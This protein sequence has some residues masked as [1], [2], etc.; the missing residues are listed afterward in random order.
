MQT[1]IRLI[2]YTKIQQSYKTS[3]DYTYTGDHGIAAANLCVS[4]KV[5]DRTKDFTLLE[6]C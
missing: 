3:E 1:G 5:F 2:Y 6:R 4:R